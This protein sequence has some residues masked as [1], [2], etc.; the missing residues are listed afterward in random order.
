VITDHREDTLTPRLRE[1]RDLESALP[2]L[3]AA[4]KV[5]DPQLSQLVRHALRD[6][7]HYHCP[8]GFCLPADDRGPTWVFVAAM[9]LESPN[10]LRSNWRVATAD[11]ARWE[12][13][14]KSCVLNALGVASW[15][16][17]KELSR[18]PVTTAKMALQVVRFVPSTRQFIRDDDNLGSSRKGATDAMKRIGLLKDD[19]REWLEAFPLYQETAPNGV[20]LTVFFLW[21]TSPSTQASLL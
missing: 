21:P 20:A 12:K 2:A 11:R 5:K 13:Q 8:I 18:Q 10:K 16:W 6:V 19:R 7:H 4:A 14:L 1:I 9:K 17:L 15:E 3:L